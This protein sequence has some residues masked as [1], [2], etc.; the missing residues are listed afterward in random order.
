[1]IR[2]QK[3]GYRA[4]HVRV[5]EVAKEAAAH[6]YETMMSN[7]EYY[8][9]WQEKHPDATEQELRKK[10]V[11]QNWKRCIDFAVST[12][13]VLLTKDDVPE[14][15]KEEIMIVLEQNQSIRRKHVAHPQLHNLS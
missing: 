3:T 2:L 10:F 4:C 11:D 9:K 12:L 8:A 5:A 14:K 15:T 7:N 1:M 13:T 6:L